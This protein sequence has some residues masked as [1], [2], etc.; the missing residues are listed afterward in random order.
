M[1]NQRGS[2]SSITCPECGHRNRASAR[3][4][5]ECYA[6]LRSVEDRTD[7]PTLRRSGSGRQAQS[8]SR[9][10]AI[11][12]KV[13][14]SHTASSYDARGTS[15]SS[16]QQ[17]WWQDWKLGAALAGFLGVMGLRKT[18]LGKDLRDIDGQDILDK[19]L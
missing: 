2:R 13:Q 19:L 16:A 8:Q 9:A 15:G 3:L 10:D 14:G 18:E 6:S 11:R 12:A 7:L 5:A 17:P 4:C 1:R